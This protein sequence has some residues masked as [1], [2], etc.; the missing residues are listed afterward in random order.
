[1]ER[2][3]EGQGACMVPDKRFKLCLK[4]LLRKRLLHVPSVS[5]QT[6]HA[7]YAL[8]SVQPPA[9]RTIPPDTRNLTSSSQEEDLKEQKKTG[10][11]GFS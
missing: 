3:S 5:R 2:E 1:M 10:R 9:D 4:M 7:L 8:F 11:Q 6:H